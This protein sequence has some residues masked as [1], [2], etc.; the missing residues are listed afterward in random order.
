MTAILEIQA[1]DTDQNTERVKKLLEK[2]YYEC[3][4]KYK[5]SFLLEIT[6][7]EAEKSLKELLGRKQI[8]ILTY[9]TQKNGFSKQIQADVPLY[10]AIRPDN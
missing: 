3:F 10:N 6:N 2:R 4:S 8:E 7:E 5:V 1:Y 9:K